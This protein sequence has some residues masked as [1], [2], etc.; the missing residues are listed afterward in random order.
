[1]KT[2]TKIKQSF[3]KGSSSYES[4]CDIQRLICHQLVNFFFERKEKITLSKDIKGL[5]LGAGNGILSFELLKF[6][7]FEKLHLIDF[8]DKML[9]LAKKKIKQ[10]FVTYEVTDFDNLNEIDK[11]NLIFSNMSFHW[12]KN[13]DVLLKKL[14][15]KISNNTLLFF[16]IPNLISFEKKEPFSN[17]DNLM[18]KF[19]DTKN[20]LNKLDKNKYFL[21]TKK[22]IFREN[23]N[24]L[25]SFFYKLRSIGANINIE[26]K[27]KSLMR[28]RNQKSNLSVFYDIN[29]VLIKKL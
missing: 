21:E 24:N 15:E 2:K 14:L 9:E 23:F 16:S 7:K 20:L 28:F 17:L 25:L 8:S 18:N 5:D 29:F 27:K 3:D 22:I 10:E 26:N 6:I 1:M 19:P 11:F 4:N 13:F 12:S